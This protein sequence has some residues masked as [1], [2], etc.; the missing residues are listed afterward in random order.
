M[1]LRIMR[2]DSAVRLGP[3]EGDTRV[4]GR[5]RQSEAF[6]TY[7]A[8]VADRET[9]VTTRVPATPEALAIRS[10]HLVVVEGPSRGLRVP[11][12]EGVARVGTAPANQ[13][14]LN[15][16]TVSRM[17]CEVRIRPGSIALSDCGSTNGTFVEGVRLE[18][19]EVQPGTIVRVG[20][21]AFRI[22]DAGGG[23]VSLPL[24]ERSSF[25]QCVGA[26]LEMRRLYAILE[27]VTQG[28]ATVLIQGET[29]TGKDVVARSLHAMSARALGPFVPIDC[30]AIPEAL[31]ES[32]LFGHVRGAFSG[33]LSDRRGVFEEAQGGT[34]F[35]DE[36]G[37]LPLHVQ[38]KLLRAIES[39]AVR[40]VGSNVEKPVDVRIVAATNRSLSRCLNEGTFREDL[41]YRLAVVEVVLP[42]LRARREDIPALA[43]H[44]YAEIGGGSALP[45]EF[46][47]NLSARS[48]PGNVRELRNFVERA[49][50]LG[51]VSDI[52]AATVPANRVALPP[53]VLEGLIPFHLPLKEARD[54]WTESFESL[55][56]Q[57]VL[58]RAGGNVRRAAAMAGVN[59]RFMQRLL[60]R[61]GLRSADSSVELPAADDSDGEDEPS[62][63]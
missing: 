52:G 40:R 35:L 23:I 15:D 51:L 22:D 11:A 45:P 28:N 55:Y 46:L 60:A 56:V 2:G 58:R 63:A 54:A 14:R 19:G 36:I 26:S 16:P 18:R 3:R 6:S 61:L 57:S 62:D 5:E 37:E 29:G 4:A 27:R 49:A 32:E 1:V 39:R 30:G 13:L 48:W 7:D 21:S 41:Y 24:S 25:G 38:A 8:D 9:D 10:I 12:H 53:D 42:P 31:I 43:R 50:S 47:A 59:R 17:H 20:A 34:L 44:F 33:A